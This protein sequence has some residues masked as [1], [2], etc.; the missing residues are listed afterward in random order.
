MYNETEV[1]KLEAKIK[2]LESENADL[3]NTILDF[4]AGR[5]QHQ[6]LIARL[7]YLVGGHEP[8]GSINIDEMMDQVEEIVN[9]GIASMDSVA[10][11]IKQNH[12]AGQTIRRMSEANINMQDFLLLLTKDIHKHPYIT[13]SLNAIMRD[14]LE[15]LADG[16]DVD[17][18]PSFDD[19]TTEE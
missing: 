7:T 3:T 6:Q 10:E 12:Q 5:R 11:L 8:S 1:K 18:D 9:E 14:N 2:A 16:V 17:L 15:A 4:G 13:K 19:Q